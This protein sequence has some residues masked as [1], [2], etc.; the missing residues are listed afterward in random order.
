[1]DID[2]HLPFE[3]VDLTS[4]SVAQFLNRLAELSPTQA[5]QQ[6]SLA[7]K[8]FA[9]QKPESPET[10]LPVLLQLAPLTLHLTTH[11]STLRPTDG[12]TYRANK[13]IV[14]LP[15]QLSQLLYQLVATKQLTTPSLASAIYHALQLLG[16]S[17]RSYCLRH[18]MPSKTLWKM[19]ARLYQVAII[20]NCTSTHQTSKIP[21]F[22]AQTTIETVVKRNL[23]FS[24]LTP[25]FFKNTDVL[26]LFH[27]ANKYAEE[28]KITR[29]RAAW[30]F[31]HFW[32]LNKDLPPT[33]YTLRK[34][35]TL[36]PENCLA[37][38]TS[39]IAAM[40]Q[41]DDLNPSIHN[42][43]SLLLHGYRPL[44]SSML[45]GKSFRAELI[46]GF[47]NSC[48]CL[49]NLNKLNQFSSV[50]NDI[51]HKEGNKGL[52][53][54]PMDANNILFDT[55]AQPFMQPK[56]LGQPV[57]VIATHNPAFVIAESPLID[58][59]TGT[60]AMLYRE[61]HPLTFAV[62]RQQQ[63]NELSHA[64]QLLLELIPGKC[65]IVKP[66]NADFE[67]II[68]GEDVKRPQAILANDQYA[69]NSE[70]PLVG[71]MTLDL[72]AHLESNLFFAR[73]HCK[74]E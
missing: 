22:K 5:A 52:S 20:K 4:D 21:D 39:Q 46:I 64:N 25:S 63:V 32:H 54:I 50:C 1:M 43:I 23:L 51:T 60:V 55:A 66:E 6:M 37:I 30:Q 41:R 19:S 44:L 59:S 18:E 29:D 72:T 74:I 34:S 26:S 12:K 27:F 28:L 24:I 42:K 48:R 58:C 49:H 13:L 47:Y 3:P 35:E 71:G 65:R 7:L 68:V 9:E 61:Q 38:D 56:N 10:I 15:R 36:L 45:P 70:L 14:H 2:N 17:M 8:H 67:A 40:L 33:P 62:V 57:N 69:Y 53:L 73:F 31:G 11:L 16:Y